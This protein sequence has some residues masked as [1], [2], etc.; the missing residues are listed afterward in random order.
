MIFHLFFGYFLLR[1]IIKIESDV[2][3]KLDS[4]SDDYSKCVDI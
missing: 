2:C 3:R 4:N 1:E